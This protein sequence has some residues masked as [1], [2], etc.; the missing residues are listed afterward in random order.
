MTATYSKVTPDLV[1]LNT[2]TFEWNIPSVSSDIGDVPSLGCH[3]ANIVG[4]YMIIAFGR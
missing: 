3:T 4:D 1:A 2:E